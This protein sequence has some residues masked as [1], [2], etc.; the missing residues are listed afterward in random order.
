[1]EKAYSDLRCGCACLELGTGMGLATDLLPHTSS[2]GGGGG[3]NFRTTSCLKAM[4]VMQ[5]I[6]LAFVGD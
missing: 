1:M 6:V 4:A 5:P 2:S 3:I